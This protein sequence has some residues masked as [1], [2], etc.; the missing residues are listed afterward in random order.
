MSKAVFSPEM[1]SAEARSLPFAAGGKLNCSILSFY[2]R[3]EPLPAFLQFLSINTHSNKNREK[4]KQKKHSKDW[5]TGFSPMGTG[6][7]SP[8]VKLGRGV[9]L[10]TNPPQ[11]PKS[12]M[13]RSYGSSTPWHLRGG[14]GT[15]LCPTMLKLSSV[16]W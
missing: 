15:Y 6:V 14:S 10:T 1:K 11:M 2:L 3:P 16:G 8:G 5:V 12:R 4:L 7:L 13:S 9:T